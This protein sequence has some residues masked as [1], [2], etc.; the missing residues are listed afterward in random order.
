MNDPNI[1]KNTLHIDLNDKKITNAKFVQINQ[2]PQFDSHS[3]SKLYVDNSIDESSLVR[4]NQD[5]DVNYYNLTNINSS[6]L[7]TQAVNDNHVITE[8]FVDQFHNNNKKTEEI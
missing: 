5:N 3:T 1:I 4:N 7:N 2:L 8:A 6:T